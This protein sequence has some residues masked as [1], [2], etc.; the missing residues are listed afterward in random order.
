VLETL[1]DVDDR[2]ESIAEICRRVNAIIAE[3][4]VPRV[5]YVHLRRLVHEHR[6]EEDA[7]R[8]R[9]EELLRIVAEMYLDSLSGRVTDPFSAAERVRRARRTER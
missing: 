6:W 4:G 8:A 9:R 7:R 5:S 1:K 3:L 2:R